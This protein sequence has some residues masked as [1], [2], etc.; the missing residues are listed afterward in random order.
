[1]GTRGA[2]GGRGLE[3]QAGGIFSASDDGK[4][5]AT[6]GGTGTGSGVEG[7]EETVP[8]DLTSILGLWNSGEY[9]GEAGTAGRAGEL[10]AEMGGLRR[11]AQW[12]NQ[13][14]MWLR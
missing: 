11:S 5:K 6:G 7:A 3:Q 4:G 8:R 1:M 12:H 10:T 14:C 13:S 9:S 2:R